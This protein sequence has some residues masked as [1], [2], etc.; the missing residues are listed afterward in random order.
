[1]KTKITRKYYQPNP[2]TNQ[3]YLPSMD[4]TTKTTPVAASALAENKLGEG[5]FGQVF[6]NKAG[7]KQCATKH[8]KLTFGEKDLPYIH[9]TTLREY[10][11]LAQCGGGYIPK[12]LKAAKFDVASDKV[13]LSMTHG[14]MNL[15][16][17]SKTLS[18]VERIKFVPSLIYQVAAGLLQL[19]NSGILHGDVKPQNILV[20]PKTKKIRVIDFGITT[21]AQTNP[22]QASY[23]DHGTYIYCPYETFKGNKAYKTSC[24]W[25]IAM[26]V[27]DFLYKRYHGVQYFTEKYPHLNNVAKEDYNYLK[28]KKIFEHLEQLSVTTGTSQMDITGI[29]AF[30]D[31]KIA[32]PGI[33]SLINKMIDMN[34]TTSRIT[35]EQI[36]QSPELLSVHRPSYIRL[37]KIRTETS[38]ATP[39]K[40]N[41]DEREGQI[42]SLTM[43]ANM[44]KRVKCLPLAVLLMDLYLSK[45]SIAKEKLYLVG[46]SCLSIA[47]CLSENCENLFD[48]L[49]SS[50]FRPFKLQDL[51]KMNLHI[52]QTL[53][54]RL[55]YRTFVMD[56]LDKYDGVVNYGIVSRVI[57]AS[58]APYDNETL[59]Q[60]YTDLCYAKY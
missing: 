54:G 23:M 26:S 29:C 52:V 35:L 9:E 42:N 34:P 53:K 30:D 32:L 18:Y 4:S 17:Y 10:A 56:L 51:F 22:E 60:R 43:T 28:I 7:Q 19:Q 33:H 11:V 14:G 38:V 46:L 2:E 44:V 15:M 47:V 40:T 27:L 8:M 24:V 25:N 36:C 55:Y 49:N 12:L 20:D 31:L 57:L 37:P 13:E 6:A 41:Q 3:L 21:F 16:D 5:S 45:V 39:W 1:L 50:L 59:A 48:D 58:S